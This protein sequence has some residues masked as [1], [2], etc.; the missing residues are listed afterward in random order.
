MDI[1]R[2]RLSDAEAAC[3]VHRRSIIELCVA[4]HGD[5]PAVLA[6]WLASKTPE[7]VRAWITR[8]DNNL[9]VAE[10]GAAILAV[11]C[12]TDAGEV[13][14]NYVSPDQRFRGISKA[15]LAKLEGT[16]RARGAAACTLTST[17]TARRFYLSAGYADQGVRESRFGA[18][19]AYRM[20]KPLV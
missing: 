1:R 11:G 5:D 17:G 13:S 18:H 15:M 16:A 4:D 20:T 7:N 8:P 9:F 10:E 14:L 6:A 12:V 19:A 2:A 3:A